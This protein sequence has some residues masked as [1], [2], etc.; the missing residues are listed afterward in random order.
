LK[1][2]LL[3]SDSPFLDTGFGQLGRGL[4]NYLHNN[5]FAVEHIGLFD[6]RNNENDNY[7]NKT[8]SWP[9]NLGGNPRHFQKKQYDKIVNEFSPDL[10]IIITDIWAAKPYLNTEVPTILYVHIEGEPLPNIVKNQHQIISCPQILAS[11]D[12]LIAAGPYAFRVIKERFQTTLSKLSTKEKDKIMKKFTTIISDG[13]EIN[14]FVPLKNKK[15]IKTQIWNVNIDSFIIGY[16]GRQNPRKG[17]PY[18]I[19]AFAKWNKPNTYLYLHTAINDPAGWD[20]HSLVGDHNVKSKVILNPSLQL[21]HGVP[22]EKLNRLYNACDITTLPSS[23]EGFGGTVCFLRNTYVKTKYEH[24]PIQWIRP[25]NYVYTHRGKLKKV[26]KVFKRHYTG[27]IYNIY[28]ETS[29][30][31]QVTPNHRFWTAKAWKTAKHLKRGDLLWYP[32]IET[33]DVEKKIVRKQLRLDTHFP[34]LSHRCTDFP[35]LARMRDCLLSM[36]IHNKLS[37]TKLNIYQ[38]I[39]LDTTKRRTNSRSKTGVVDNE[40]RS[41][42]KTPITK[43]VGKMYKGYV[44][45][46]EVE[47]DNT[48]IVNGVAYAHNCDS[49]STGTPAVITDY[50]ELKNF[51]KG[52][53]FIRPVGFYVEPGTNIRRAIPSI[54][55]ITDSFDILYND[56]KLIKSLGES[57]RKDVKKYSWENIGPKWVDVINKMIPDEKLFKTTNVA[58]KEPVSIIILNKDRYDLL[59]TCINHIRKN[60]KYPYEIVIIDNGSTDVNTVN[61][62]KQIKQNP[63]IRV[64]NHPEEFNFSR[65]CNLGAKYSK[66]NILCF[67]NNDAFVE[68][69]WLNN[70]VEELAKPKVGVVGAKLLFQDGTIQHAGI[71]IDKQCNCKHSYIGKPGG[72]PQANETKEVQAVTGACFMTRHDLF[73]KLGCFSIQ[74]KMESSDVDYSLK[75]EDV[76]Y[77]TIYAHKA[78]AKHITCATR[79]RSGDERLI[80]DRN[81][82]KSKWCDKLSNKPDKSVLINTNNLL[83]NN[84]SSDTSSDTPLISIII[85]TYNCG[86]YFP[87]LISSIYN[88]TYKHFEIIIVNDGS[89]DDTE[90]ILKE[91]YADGYKFK[92]INCNKHTNANIAREKGYEKSKGDYLLFSDADSEWDPQMLEKMAGVL[93]DNPKI[94]YAYSDYKRKGIINDTFKTINFNASYLKKSNYISMMS[95]IRKKDFPGLDPYI[96]RAQDWDLWLTMLENNKIGKHIPEPLFMAHVRDN[97]ITGGSVISWPDA[98]NIVKRK[99]HMDNKENVSIILT[100]KNRASMLHRMF[101]TISNQNYKNF[102][103]IISD[104]HSTD[105]DFNDLRQKFKFPIRIVQNEKEFNRSCGLNAGAAVAKYSRLFF[106]DADMLFPENF[107]DIMSSNIKENQACFPICKNEKTLQ[108]ADKLGWRKGGYGNCGIHKTDFEKIGKWPESFQQWGGEDNFMFWKCGA[109]NIKTIRD[110]VSEFIHQDHESAAPQI[111]SKEFLNNILESKKNYIQKKGKGNLNIALIYDSPDWAIHSQAKGFINN[112]KSDVNY[113]AYSMREFLTLNLEKYDMIFAMASFGMSRANFAPALLNRPNVTMV[114]HN[115]YSI[116][117]EN[118]EIS[119]NIWIKNEIQFIQ[120]GLRHSTISENII[121]AWKDKHSI[122][123]YYLPSGIDTNMFKFHNILENNAITIGWVGNKNKKLKGYYDIIIPAIDIVKKQYPNVIFKTHGYE[124]LIPHEKMPEFYS[125]ID[126][127]ICASS[128]EGLPTPLV[129]TCA[130]GIPFVSTEVGVTSE[131]NISYLNCI[132]NRDVDSLADGIIKMIKDPERMKQAGLSNRKIIVAGWSWDIVADIWECFILGDME[133]F[134]QIHSKRRDKINNI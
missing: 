55:E 43:I 49:L 110:K 106:T 102:E 16:F 81:M 78:V 93:K 33:S 24:K 45:N 118:S 22:I 1:K 89:T 10:I 126:L 3:I 114:H 11:A 46:L 56:R 98:V 59:S 26:L 35:I 64:Y 121:Q 2:I 95:L 7:N 41:Y 36:G 48:Y 53:M 37:K 4:G 131:I 50:S 123:A 128:N 124:N 117:L 23:G 9:V 19:E 134:H 116:G 5:G 72:H 132:V 20:L 65:F 85:P 76:G 58:K 67:L 77:K 32:I 107:T 122:D 109:E 84:G 57:G 54:S 120:N 100:L 69:D 13:C 39:A 97:S 80:D 115:P 51:Q 91:L 133:K 127:Y 34:K 111:R 88:Q 105:I 14:K 119:G 30:P 104:F 79:S 68:I 108:C 73:D 38:N 12:K 75:A 96:Q 99:H 86:K 15:S 113:T 21:G 94:S 130:C 29:T 63:A 83:I 92:V 70:M 60:T 112:I 17:L 90:N 125:D 31:I 62:L 71:E 129:E 40:F 27:K 42:V 6:P 25:G 28:T 101:E 74:Y 82:F 103:I 87:D 66:N 47:D 8:I 61:Y 44:Y 52:T 18:A